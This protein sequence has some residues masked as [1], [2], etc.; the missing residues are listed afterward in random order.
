[1][2]LVSER[3]VMRGMLSMDQSKLRE[4]GQ[5]RSQQFLAG[6]W[7]KVRLRVRRE[8]EWEAGLSALEKEGRLPPRAAARRLRMA[9]RLRPIW[10]RFF[11]LLPARSSRTAE[12]PNTVTPCS[13]ARVAAA[14]RRAQSRPQ[15]LLL[16]AS[17]LSR[18]KTAERSSA[19]PTIP[20][21]A[22]VWTGWA[23][24]RRAAVRAGAG[25]GRAVRR[26]QWKRWV[27]RACRIMLV[28][29]NCA[30][31]PGARSQSR[32]K[33]REVRGRYDL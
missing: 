16:W 17:R 33:E 2:F 7:R 13:L 9:T 11:L 23:A 30:A 1:M 18:K 5:S 31:E 22:S 10:R 14:A 26:R 6:R 21:T 29:W 20:A 24:N 12:T 8:D 19:R 25:A 3:E 32:W 28:R 27:A 4:E 15:P